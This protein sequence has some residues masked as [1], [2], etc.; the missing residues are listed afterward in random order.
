MTFAFMCNAYYVAYKV[1]RIS[2][3]IDLFT[4]KTRNAECFQFV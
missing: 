2:L 3:Y 4:S 1:T